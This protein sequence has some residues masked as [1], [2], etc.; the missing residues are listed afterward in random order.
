MRMVPFE[1][2]RCDLAVYAVRH[3]KLCNLSR[4]NHSLIRDPRETARNCAW[5]TPTCRNGRIATTRRHRPRY[6]L[7]HSTWQS[8][9]SPHSVLVCIFSSAL[10]LP[11]MSCTSCTKTPPRDTE[12]KATLSPHL[13][14]AR[15]S[16]HT[17]FCDFNT[18]LNI[19]DVARSALF[20]A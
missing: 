11:E 16:L 10:V 17:R 15:P 14:T 20:T 19:L 9:Q 18:L 5:S 4:G 7:P 1:P 6:M 3:D 12:C 13:A 8:T 2:P